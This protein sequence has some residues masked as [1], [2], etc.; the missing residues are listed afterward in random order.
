MISLKYL[1]LLIFLISQTFADAK[2]EEFLNY[3]Q[4]V[5]EFCKEK[6]NFTLEYDYL[7]EDTFPDNYELKCLMECVAEE[8]QIV[9]DRI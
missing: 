6:E 7:L 1:F 4:E 8:L 2:F 9:S 5:A 3:A